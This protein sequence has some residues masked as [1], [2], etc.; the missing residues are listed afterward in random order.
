MS[1][2]ICRDCHKPT[3]PLGKCQ[4]CTAR[5]GDYSRKGKDRSI[6]KSSSKWGLVPAPVTTIVNEEAKP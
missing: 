6:V 2:R 3:G 5:R 4:T 1:K